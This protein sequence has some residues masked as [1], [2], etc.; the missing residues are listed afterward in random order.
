M[1]YNDQQIK[2]AVDAVF[3]KYD[4]DGS[5]SLDAKEVYALINDALSHMKANRSVS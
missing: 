5:N 1:S 4:T 2:A 3:G